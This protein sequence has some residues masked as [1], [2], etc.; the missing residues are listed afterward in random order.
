M[1][2][3]MIG[4]WPAQWRQARRPSLATTATCSAWKSP[5]GY[6]LRKKILA[7]FALALAVVSAASRPA[8]AE[9]AYQK[10]PQKVLDVLLA[11]LPPIAVIDPT[12]HTMLLA[13]M[14]RYPPI[15]DLAEPMLR[16]AGSRVIPK[17]RRL[18]DEPYC[19]A[20]ELVRLPGGSQRHINSLI[21]AGRQRADMGRSNRAA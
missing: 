10:P 19:N 6:M 2:P 11:P 16:L 13:T 7:A 8:R 17:T 12:H 15:A 4:I 1:I 20:Y 9:T 21:A 18:Q 14:V 5:R 3:E